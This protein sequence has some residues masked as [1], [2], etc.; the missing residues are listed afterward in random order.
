MIEC[1]NLLLQSGK[2]YFNVKQIHNL[3]IIA[4]K[5]KRNV[6]RLIY[7]LFQPAPKINLNVIF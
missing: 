4:P 5:T 3:I 2:F 6:I 7:L 1:Q